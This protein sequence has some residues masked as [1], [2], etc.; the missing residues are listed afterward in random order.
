MT[1]HPTMRRILQPTLW[2]SLLALGC[3][4][5]F[6]KIRTFDYWWHLRT[7][8]LILETG[9]VPKVDV[10]SYTVPG[11]PY[12]DIHWL[13]QIALYTIYSLGGHA[14]VVV[15]K[16]VFICAMVAILATIGWR[17]DRPV[18]A[19]FALA[20]MLAAAADRFMPR[21]ELPSFLFLAGVLAL[22]DR[23]ERR[24]DAWVYPILA[25][26]LLWVNVHGLFALGIAVC[27]IYLG[28]EILRPLLQ[29][30][31]S[32]RPRRIRRLLTLTALAT[33][34]SLA[35]PNFIDGALYPIQ[36]L[37]MI[38]PPEE[39]GF[40][41]SLIA[42]LI[43]P[44][45]G[46]GGMNPLAI[47][48]VA[49]LGATAFV[50]MV[51]NWRHLSAAH[52]L[53][54]VSFGYLALGARRNL[55]LFAIVSTPIVVRNL[56][57]F[58]DR[59]SP[60]PRLYDA[61]AGVAF[62]LVV[63]LTVLV[64]RD[65]YFNHLGTSR[66]AGFGVFEY[67]YPIGAMEW[68]AENR[69][70]GPIAHHMADGGYLIWRLYP[71]YRSMTD[72][73]LEVFGAQTFADLQIASPQHL[74]AL[75]EKYG[76]GSVLVHYNLANADAML[77]SLYLDSNWRLVFVDDV[78][79]LFARVP[80]SGEIP[81]PELD[82]DDP[83]LFPPLGSEPSQTDQWTRFSRVNFLTSVRRFERA[84]ELWEETVDRYPDLEQGP[85]IHA[86]LLQRTGK[87]AAAQAILTR[88]LAERPDDA[89]L[90]TQIG[91]LHLQAGETSEARDYFDRALAI[92]PRMAYAL[93]R[94]GALAEDEHD[95]DYA[96][97]LYTRALL[98]TQ[99]LDPISLQAAR[100]ITAMGR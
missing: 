64:A 27:G 53:L 35:N 79:A 13:H 82:L 87:P 55:A 69:P 67:F 95:T 60:A 54:W 19:V 29:P 59:R 36:Q 48:L 75:N 43:P 74:R 99:P 46:K 10:Y 16:A 66:E 83:D 30:G 8:Q 93:V 61:F 4:F 47:G 76:F 56:N 42:E 20:W 1:L 65:Q 91:D 37:G 70:A 9:A 100:R 34:V 3:A 14:A 41:G 40:F 7:G 12:I 38:G 73:R 80:T 90:L 89:A 97:A 2:L 62:V 86:M 77:W 71:E 58:L 88:L 25:I 39:R 50:A 15:T 45:G 84:L 23:H 68:I 31:T 22:L 6:Q 85:V 57:E 92:D 32:L 94:R 81:W 5:G 24:G 28:A 96:L 78:A 44:L 21:P 72:G 63:S 51:L 11:A 49:G 26:Q 18:V 17:R 33:L 52:P 98:A